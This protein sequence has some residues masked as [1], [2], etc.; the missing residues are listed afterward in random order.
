MAEDTIVLL[1]ADYRGMLGCR[2]KC[3]NQIW[4]AFDRRLWPAPATSG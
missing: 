2:G 1:T 4:H 3:D